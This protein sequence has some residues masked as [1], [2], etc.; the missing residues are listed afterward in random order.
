VQSD[1]TASDYIP[2]P[3]PYGANY[4]QPTLTLNQCFPLVAR[5]HLPAIC[6]ASLLPTIDRCDGATESDAVAAAA[7]AGAAWVDG[8]TDGRPT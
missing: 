4:T 1:D 2:D 3:L 8:K 7:A 5:R 6:L